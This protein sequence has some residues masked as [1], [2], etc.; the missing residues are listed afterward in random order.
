MKY[1]FTA[2]P[3]E[4]IPLT[5]DPLLRHLT[6]T[7]V[8]ETNKVVSTW[9]AFS[10]RH[11]EFRAHPKSSSVL[12][13]MKHQLL[14]ER[15][16]FGEFLGTYEPAAAAIEPEVPTVRSYCETLTALAI[17][18][19]TFLSERDSPWWLAPVPFFDVERE[20][21]WIFWRR[22]LH[23]AHHRTQLS[24]YLRL[25]DLPVPAI[26]GPTADVTWSGADPTN[27]AA[28]AERK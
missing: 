6:Q 28:A 15:R 26:Y 21:I 9:R 22:I 24:V 27:T 12:E 2:I 10:D 13:I 18:R 20:R 5:R 23:T 1:A 17:E 8:S 4:S 14:S 25:L 7:Y 16:F 11:L 3:E 19:L